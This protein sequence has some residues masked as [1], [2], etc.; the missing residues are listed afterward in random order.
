MTQINRT[1]SS[2]SV[3]QYSSS[4]FRFSISIRIV[5]NSKWWME[6]IQLSYF[7]HTLTRIGIRYKMFV[8]KMYRIEK[9]WFRLCFYNFFIGFFLNFLVCSKRLVVVSSMWW[10]KSFFYYFCSTMF[11]FQKLACENQKWRCRV[12]SL[13]SCFL[14]FYPLLFLHS[15]THWFFLF[16][17]HQNFMLLH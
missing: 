17:S 10:Y 1:P 4:S 12:H 6:E 16:H 14:C 3:V 7:R 11:V 9:N 15:N 13:L 5:L 8:D 2:S